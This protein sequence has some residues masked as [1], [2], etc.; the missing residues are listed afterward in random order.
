MGKVSRCL[1]PFRDEGII[2]VNPDISLPAKQEKTLR[3]QRHCTGFQSG[4][5]ITGRSIRVLRETRRGISIRS[6]HFFYKFIRT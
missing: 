1:S 6:V 2:S 5:I 3:P 4:Y